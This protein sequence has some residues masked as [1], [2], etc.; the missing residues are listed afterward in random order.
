MVGSG[1]GMLCVGTKE[2]GHVN[3]VKARIMVRGGFELHGLRGDGTASRS[4]GANSKDGEGRS[5]RAST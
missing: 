4:S 5:E 1:Y 3:V 2:E